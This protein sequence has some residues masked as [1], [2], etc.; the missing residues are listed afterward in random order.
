MHRDK[1][2]ATLVT[3]HKTTSL[4]FLETLRIETIETG[5]PSS[6]RTLV[7]DQR[8]KSHDV[9]KRRTWTLDHARNKAVHLEKGGVFESDGGHGGLCRRRRCRGGSHG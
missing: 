2:N 6:L 4:E 9:E 8:Q 3:W 7:D 1:E 5:G